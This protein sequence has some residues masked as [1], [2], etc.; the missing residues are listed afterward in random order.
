MNRNMQNLYNLIHTAVVEAINEASE[1][2][3]RQD[4]VFGKYLWADGD[5]RMRKDDAV[6]PNSKEENEFL[7]ALRSFV[8][9]NQKE[10]LE[11]VVKNYLLRASSEGL[12]KNFIT[13]PAGRKIYRGMFLPITLA[14]DILEIPSEEILKSKRS[15]SGPGI[16][17]TNESELMSWT[18]DKEKAIGF[19]I[20]GPGADKWLG[21]NSK[22]N[23]GIVFEANTSNGNFFLDYKNLNKMFELGVEISS[24]LRKEKEVI[25]YGPVKFEQAYFSPQKKYALFKSNLQRLT[26]IASEDYAGSVTANFMYG[27]DR[28][29]GNEKNP[30]EWNAPADNVKDFAEE[31]KSILPKIKLNTE[32]EL[33]LNLANDLGPQNAQANFKVYNILWPILTAEGWSAEEDNAIAAKAVYNVMAL[34]M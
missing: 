14:S 26:E 4:S 25:S 13:P 30:E 24:L 15:K 31:F 33:A 17:Q 8:V 32:Y 29:G 18:F 7:H 1:P 6:E 21:R 22:K 12:Y 11:Y 27:K 19:S 16:L 28:N 5:A 10:D 20:E 3:A 2:E 23:V 34:G 9:D